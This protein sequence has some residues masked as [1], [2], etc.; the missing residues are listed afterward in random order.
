MGVTRITMVSPSPMCDNYGKKEPRWVTIY[1][2]Q[3]E[4]DE[5]G[6]CIRS[7]AFIKKVSRDRSTNK[8]MSI[9]PY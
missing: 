5:R 6:Y 3:P 8:I 4:Y 2:R 7:G 1:H 9:L